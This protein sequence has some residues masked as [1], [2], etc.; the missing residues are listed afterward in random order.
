MP[1]VT[2]AAIIAKDMI[3]LSFDDDMRVNDALSNTSSYTITPVGA[4]IAV[5]VTDVIAPP[6][7]SVRVLYLVTTVGSTDTEYKVTIT[8]NLR[9][10]NNQALNPDHTFMRTRF[11]KTDSMIANTPN[12]YDTR[13]GSVYRSLI[14]AFG[15]END[16]IGGSQSEVIRVSTLNPEEAVGWRQLDRVVVTSGTDTIDFNAVLTEDTEEI[17]VRYRIIQPTQNSIGGIRWRINGVNAAG[18]GV[19]DSASMEVGFSS[20]THTQQLESLNAS[21]TI[22]NAEQIS[23]WATLRILKEPNGVAFHRHTVSNAT[24]HNPG[25]GTNLNDMPLISGFGHYEA[26]TTDITTIGLFNVANTFG[27]GSVFELWELVT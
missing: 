11:T 10:T 18:A 17:Q 26:D 8:G 24:M 3:R 19:A 20:W 4:G 5:S 15:I 14:G 21:G 27:V 9:S 25:A 12:V 2:E 23:G 6:T 13:P 22:T 7:G 1:T 16:L